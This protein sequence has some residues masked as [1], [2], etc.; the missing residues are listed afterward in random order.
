M[1]CLSK[2]PFSTVQWL[3]RFLGRTLLVFDRRTVNAINLNLLTC[4]PE[5]A[6]SKRHKLRD[7]RLAHM[8]QT[9]LEMSHLWTKDVSTLLSYLQPHYDNSLFEEAIKGDK[10]VI[11]LA[12]HLGNWEVMN[13]YLGQFCEPTFMYRPQ[14]SKQLDT[15][16]YESRKRVGANLAPAN[17]KGVAQLIKSL[18]KS[19]V[20]GILPDQ[21]PQEGGG[22]YANFYGQS[23]YTMTLAQKLA[24]KTQARVFIAAAYQVKG[25]YQ[26]RVEPVEQAFYDED[27]HISARALN[28]SIEKLVK[29]YPAQYQWEY[30]RFKKQANGERF[31]PKG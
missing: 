11:F 19:G 1:R 6:E 22:V 31:Y 18:N 26:V 12:P 14:R 3:G 30:K 5:L 13:C 4:F 9:L 2:V 10:G 8:G 24:Q 23:A 16:I 7:A 17:N 27:A 21:V 29:D 28:L 20:V 25:G 15:F